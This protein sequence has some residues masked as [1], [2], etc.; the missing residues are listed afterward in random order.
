MQLTRVAWLAALAWLA[1]CGSSGKTLAI[2]LSLD[3]S[4]GSSFC[5]MSTCQSP[6]TCPLDCGGEVGLYLIDAE[7]EQ[8]LDSSCTEIAAVA[9]STLRNLPAILSDGPA[10]GANISA[11]KQVVVQLAVFSPS[12]AGH[13]CPRV[14]SD[15]TG[16]PRTLDGEL[17]AYFATT[18]PEA[19]ITIADGTTRVDLPVQCVFPQTDC[20]SAK[21]KASS[22]D[23][24]SLVELDTPEQ[25]D[26]VYGFLGSDGDMGTSF[27][28]TSRLTYDGSLP[29]IW[30]ARP[31]NGLLTDDY[32]PATLVTLSGP[33]PI[34]VLSCEGT[35][36]RDNDVVTEVDTRGY[37]IDK[38]TIGGILAALHLPAVP[39]SGML[40]G[41][42]VDSKT[43][44]E[45]EGAAVSPLFGT[46]QPKYLDEGPGEH[47]FTL[48]EGAPGTVTGPKGWF[49]FYADPNA[50]PP[51]PAPSLPTPPPFA[52][53]IGPAPCCEYFRADNGIQTGC[54]A[55]RVGLVNDTVMA[56]VIDINGACPVPTP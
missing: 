18:D 51:V 12:S 48:R 33:A 54:S 34:P 40:I 41:K 17:P 14:F 6:D 50:T 20:T 9:D 13:D 35:A 19:P 49:V 24:S 22:Y 10:L 56:T 52:M 16:L 5:A 37:F 15:P 31:T 47:Q 25:Y 39:A 30:S 8:L 3:S 11:G 36:Q 7:T 1:A 46:A 29:P 38:A 45:V 42:V 55:G 44:S 43:F 4:P 26:F 2:R 32:C 28:F 23:V 53:G 21:V 27:V